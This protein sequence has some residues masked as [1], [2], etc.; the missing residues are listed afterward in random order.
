LDIYR[1]IVASI[2]EFKGAYKKVYPICF[3]EFPISIVNDHRRMIS[4]ANRE[5][6]ETTTEAINKYENKLESR[7][8]IILKYSLSSLN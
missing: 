2:A 4:T 3:S 8:L 1:K 5:I 7:S 6:M